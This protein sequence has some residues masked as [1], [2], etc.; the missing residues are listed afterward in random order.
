MSH[1]GEIPDGRDFE[2]I[3]TLRWTRSAGFYLL[4]RHVARLRRSAAALRFRCG[5]DEVRGA[6]AEAVEV[7]PRTRCAFG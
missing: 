5:E 3:E 2:L 1:Q 4:D 6:L 7:E